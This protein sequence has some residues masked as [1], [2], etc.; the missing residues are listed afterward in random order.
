M[1]SYF[2]F[3]L[4]DPSHLISGSTTTP[5]NFILASSF[6]DSF[7]LQDLSRRFFGKPPSA[8]KLLLVEI[9]VVSLIQN[10][11]EIN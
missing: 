5:L 4:T 3:G 6:L 9:N 7:T 1:L 10:L 2:Y 8:S 11:R